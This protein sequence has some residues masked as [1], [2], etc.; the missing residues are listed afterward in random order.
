M[1]KLL[2][3]KGEISFTTKEKNGY[4]RTQLP[5]VKSGGMKVLFVKTWS[6]ISENDSLES[7]KDGILNSDEDCSDNIYTHFPDKC[8]KTDLNK[9]DTDGDGWWDE[10]EV[11]AETNPNNSSSNP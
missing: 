2:K 1:I 7:D 3:S 10:I 11:G 6:L 4:G 8:I 5:F 9:Q